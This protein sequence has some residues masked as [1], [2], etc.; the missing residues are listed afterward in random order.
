MERVNMLNVKKEWRGSRD[1]QGTVRLGI[2]QSCNELLRKLEENYPNK[3][4]G[5]KRN[6]RQ[7][8]ERKV[9]HLNPHEK[10]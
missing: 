6:K 3:G 7:N 5:K 2:K 8:K 10:N 4:R 9:P 1:G